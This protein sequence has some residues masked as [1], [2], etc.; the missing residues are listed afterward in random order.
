M[1]ER[2]IGHTNGK[3]TVGGRQNL[4]IDLGSNN[5]NNFIVVQKDIDSAAPTQWNGITI[6]WFISF[7][8]RH[9]NV[10]GSAGAF[11]NIT[12]TITLDAIPTGKR[13]FAYYDNTVHE[14]L[15]RTVGKRIS[16]SLSVGDPPIGMG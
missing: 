1:S 14:L 7:G 3:F 16:T 6:E 13:L 15:Y 11:A 5:P 2:P 12:H 8:I 10:D 9:K 4:E